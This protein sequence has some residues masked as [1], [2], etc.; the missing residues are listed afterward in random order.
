MEYSRVLVPATSVSSRSTQISSDC[1]LLH[2]NKLSTHPKKT[3]FAK[4]D[5]KILKVSVK[6]DSDYE[7]SA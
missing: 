7:P 2:K 4:D 5:P 3:N 1:D 6:S